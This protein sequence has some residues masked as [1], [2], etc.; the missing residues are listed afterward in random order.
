MDKQANFG[1]IGL[2]LQQN[3]TVHPNHSVNECELSL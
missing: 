1:N 3:V 2:N